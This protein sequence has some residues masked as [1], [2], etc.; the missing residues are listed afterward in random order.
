MQHLPERKNIIQLH[1]RQNDVLF[2]ADAQFT[3]AIKICR[4]GQKA[5]L[6]CSCIARH[7]ADRLGGDRHDCIATGLVRRQIGRGKAREFRITCPFC[8]EYRRARGRVKFGRGKIGRYT[9]KF[10]RVGIGARAVEGGKFSFNIGFDLLQAGLMHQNLDA[11]LIFIV[12]AAIAVIDAQN[13]GEIGQ[14]VFAG[15]EVAHHL[16]HHRRAAQTAA[17]NH[18]VA[19]LAPVVTDNSQADIM[20][21]NGGA[22]IGGAGH[23]HLELARQIAIFGMGGR[24]LADQLGGR[25]RI[26]NFI[27]CRTGKMVGCDITDAVARRLNGVH[28][29]LSQRLQNIRHV[30]EFRP[31]ELQ[32]LACGEVAIATVPLIRNHGQ[33]AHLV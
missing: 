6:R 2:M 4:I 13:G 20:Q 32:V 25:A 26:L 8:L 22:V 30:R 18:A 21:Q 16:A 31:V 17:G 1:M 12:T 15:Q 19:D 14:Q 27:R 3:G 33:L 11:R 23:R 7:T 28:L 29:H 24:P 5:H 10:F 9:G